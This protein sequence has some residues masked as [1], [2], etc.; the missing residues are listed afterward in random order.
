[1]IEEGIESCCGE[2]DISPMLGWMCRWLVVDVAIDGRTWMRLDGNEFRISTFG[3][4]QVRVESMLLLLKSEL[5]QV[6]FYKYVPFDDSC[7]RETS[8]ALVS[9]FRWLYLDAS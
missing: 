4:A 8:V 1:M 6:A 3:I 7:F 5:S 2:F 9:M